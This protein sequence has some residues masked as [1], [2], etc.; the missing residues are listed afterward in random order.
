[1]R[2]D[3]RDLNISPWEQQNSFR[4]GYHYKPA[5]EDAELGLEKLATLDQQ[6]KYHHYPD[7][8]GISIH[9]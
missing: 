7:L 8:R 3:G 1:M 5:I 2:Y 4:V 6:P 9:D